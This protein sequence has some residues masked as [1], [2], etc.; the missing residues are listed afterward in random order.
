VG[1]RLKPRFTHLLALFVG[2]ATL[3]CTVDVHVIHDGGGDDEQSE[4]EQPGDDGTDGTDDGDPI[5]DLPDDPEPE[6]QALCQVPSGALDGHLPC[7]MEPP[8]ETIAPAI[9]W[10]WTGPNG[11]DSVLTTPLVANL[12]DDNG[13]GFVD[14]CDTPELVVA[15]VDLPP[16]KTDVWPAGHLHVI[17]GDGSSSFAISTPIDAAI[18]PAL[19][20]LDGDGVAELV[21]LQAAAPNSPYAISDRRLV[22]FSASGELLWTGEHWQASR[23]GGALAI[24]DLDGDGSPELLAPEYVATADGA[25]AWLIPDPPLANS[26]PVAVDLDLDGELEVL[27]G[28]SAYSASGAWLFTAPAIPQNRGSVAVANFDDDPYPELYV[29]YE[30]THG[31][32]EH[33]G[34]FKTECPTAMVDIVGVG[35]YPVAIHDL[36]GDGHAELVFGLQDSFHVLSVANDLCE[37]RWSK[38]VDTNVGSSSGTVFDLLGDGGAEAIY[39][40][41]S[42]VQLFSSEGEL[43]FMTSRSAR[44]SIT[45]PIVADIDGDG[46]AEIV[47]ASSEPVLDD[48]DAVPP[49]PTLLVLANA[50]DR[51]AP[52]RRVWNQHT[53]HHSN[54]RED[55]RVPQEAPHW[56]SENSFRA[57]SR[58]KS[59]DSCIPPTLQ[60]LSP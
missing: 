44:E 58:I 53:Y 17:A 59:G 43:L 49:T 45:N 10:T 5:P 40:D 13:D 48:V 38:K 22:A 60:S 11:E 50:D 31:I 34:S 15:A 14:L 12:D 2:P 18:N 25:L 27:F 28:A 35:G 56:W 29:Q 21:A 1:D 46:A 19:G 52:A 39:A 47:I 16:G 3:G 57:N 51:F 4:T 55:G 9:A 42:R 33:D 37:L 32:F 20:D 24:A 26:M 54:V 7:L 8:S 41:R 23:G 30:G 6:P 36:D